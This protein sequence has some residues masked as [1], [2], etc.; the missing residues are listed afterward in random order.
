MLIAKDKEGMN[1][2]PEKNNIGRIK[3]NIKNNIK[4]DIF[5][6]K[7]SNELLVKSKLDLVSITNCLISVIK[8]E[9]AKIQKK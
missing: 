9:V 8:G 6:W 5:N 3:I 7:K 2:A 4:I 1:K